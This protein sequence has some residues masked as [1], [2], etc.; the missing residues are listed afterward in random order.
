MTPD[1]APT[2]P[3][4]TAGSWPDPDPGTRAEPYAQARTGQDR[5]GR[6]GTRPN[7]SPPLGVEVSDEAHLA[8]LAHLVDVAGSQAQVLADLRGCLT[9]L[10]AVEHAKVALAHLTA[11]Q[12]RRVLRTRAHPHLP[13]G[14]APTTAP[15]APTHHGP[16]GPAD[17]GSPA[18]PGGGG[19]VAAADIS[20]A[21]DTR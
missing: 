2:P 12:L 18:S 8:H 19:G 11:D 15:P 17:P 9:R 5:D 7:S 1:P 21:G 3:R 16:G 4:S 6:P 20:P 10:D 14:R 13:A